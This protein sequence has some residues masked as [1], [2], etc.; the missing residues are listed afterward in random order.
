MY[1]AHWSDE[2]FVHITSKRYID[3]ADRTISVKVYS[4]CEELTLYVNG[5]ELETK[6]GHRIFTFENIELQDGM[7][8]IKVIA[9]HDGVALQ[10]VAKF[11][12]VAEPNPSYEAPEAE[13]GGVVANWF[14]MPDLGDE[15]VEVEEIHITDDVYSTA[16]TFKDLMENEE[17]KAVLE[18]YLGN[19]A[20]HPMFGMAQGMQ[21]DFIASMDEDLFNEK[22]MYRLNKELTQIKKS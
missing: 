18:K 13:T 12:K 5:K 3:R 22:L 10:D 7:N 9:N 8:E 4:N 2:K 17:A 6:S 20:E 14:Q 21:V 1:K 16:D 19:F 15:E 11:N